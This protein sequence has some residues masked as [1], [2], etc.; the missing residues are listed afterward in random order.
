MVCTEFYVISHL[1]GNRWFLVVLL[2]NIVF[3]TSEFEYYNLLLSFIELN[4]KTDEC[5]SNLDKF[6]KAALF[7]NG[8]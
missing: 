4:L 7:G 5:L 3:T 2:L 8:R 1:L 6:K